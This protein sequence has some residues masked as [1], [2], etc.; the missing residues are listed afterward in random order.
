M[1]GNSVSL[2]GNNF[3]VGGHVEEYSTLSVVESDTGSE[4]IVDDLNTGASSYKDDTYSNDEV[5][6]TNFEYELDSPYGDILLK[7]D[8]GSLDINEDT[9]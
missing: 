9:N 6:I 8:I 1:F 4:I 5:I 3:L 7:I 2:I